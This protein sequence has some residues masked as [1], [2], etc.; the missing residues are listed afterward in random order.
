VPPYADWLTAATDLQDAIDAAGA[1][2]F[3]LATNGV[4]SSGGRPVGTGITNRVVISRPMGVISVNGPGVT[5][6]N[7]AWDPTITNGP[8]AIRAVWLVDGAVLSGFTVQNGA[9]GG[10]DYGG[11]LYA[12]STNAY[13]VNC[14]LTNNQTGMF[15]GGC[16]QG[17]LTKCTLVD[18]QSVNEG[19]G[20]FQSFIVNSLLSRNWSRGGGG[21]SYNC[22][23][24]NSTLSSNSTPSAGG[25]SY[26]D[27]IYGSIISGNLAGTSG[28]GTYNSSLYNCTVVGNYGSFS[29]GCGV[30]QGSARNCIIYNNNA[31]AGYTSWPNYYAASLSYCCTTPA[32]G[33]TGN[34][35]SYPQLLDGVH[36]ATISPCRGAG[37]AAYASGSDIDGEPWASPPSI[38]CDEVWEANLTGPL[39]VSL[40][41]KYTTIAQY[42]QDGLSGQ[43]F[44]RATRVAWDFGDGSVLTNVSSIAY[45]K[46][47]TNPGDYTVTFT[48]YNADNPAGVSTNALIHVV[49]LVSPSV[50]T[51]ALSGKT[52]ALTFNSQP[53]VNYVVDETTNLVPPSVWNSIWYV[54]G[55]G[56][57]VQGFDHQATDAARFYRVRSQPWPPPQF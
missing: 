49:P 10:N 47:W 31:S 5:A 51:F 37:S 42:G 22:M 35:T 21:A 29:G 2:D 26:Q 9:T 41:L 48:A 30:F 1:G 3:V 52:F 38:G 43:V 17:L 53:G 32:P 55:T 34:I 23:I 6:I 33:G 56:T 39:A 28:G 50:G 14:V 15:G 18:N 16:Y 27:T 40:I 4:Y 20:A 44:G 12:T 7:G 19:G 24:I 13:V 46:V 8:A 57:N 25:A 36:I 45:P 11:G 54:I